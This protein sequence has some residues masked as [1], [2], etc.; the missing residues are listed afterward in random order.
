MAQATF[1]YAE[2]IRNQRDSHGKP[3]ESKSQ[4][5]KRLNGAPRL[6]EQPQNNKSTH[7]VISRDQI[8]SWNRMVGE[9]AGTK[10]W[11]RFSLQNEYKDGSRWVYLT[12]TASI[13]VCY[14]EQAGE[15]FFIKTTKNR[16]SGEN[17]FWLYWEN[18]SGTDSERWLLNEM[19]LEFFGV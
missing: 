9:I 3:T 6:I 17:N 7:Q 1:N 8:N 15:R 2:A 16:I 12:H 5:I 14:T 4:P 19:A 10:L 11:D 18:C 13:R